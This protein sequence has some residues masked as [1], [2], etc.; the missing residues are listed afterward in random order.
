MKSTILLATLL[1]TTPA[2]SG[3]A[4]I[5]YLNFDQA[6]PGTYVDDTVYTPGSTEHAAGPLGAS[7]G[8]FLF[9]FRAYDTVAP[10]GPTIGPLPGGLAGTP[11]GGQALIVDGS[12]GKHMGMTVEV[13]NGVATQDLTI[14]AIWYTTDP[15]ASGNNVGIQSIIGDEWPGLGAGASQFFIRTVGPNRMDWWTDRGDSNSE[16]VQITATPSFNANTLYHDVLVFD[17]NDGDPAN[18]Q[19]LAYRN[20]SLVGT[21][22]YNATGKT[23]A[24]FPTN[25]NNGTVGNEV[26]AW[27]IGMSLAAP[28]SGTDDRGLRG[29]V[30]AVAISNAALAPGSFVLPAGT[31]TFSAAG[32]GWKIYQ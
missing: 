4:T 11:Q 25:F 19:I 14:E 15:A 20:A 8:N 3:A 5:L 2:L 24:I 12:A 6:T 13:D 27:A 22:T 18:S 28:V 9:K 16:D 26:R 29:G 21:D 17:Y 31:V 1:L 32:D 10:N 7:V 30:D 23:E